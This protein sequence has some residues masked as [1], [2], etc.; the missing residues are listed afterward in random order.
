MRAHAP[1]EA[2]VRYVLLPHMIGRAGNEGVFQEQH[3]L[4]KRVSIQLAN[5]AVARCC[6]V[7]DYF[8]QASFLDDFS[9]LLTTG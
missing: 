3:Q 7:V 5:H 6:F 4:R 1:L 9:R 2:P 8:L